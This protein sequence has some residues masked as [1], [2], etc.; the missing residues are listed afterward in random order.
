MLN[1]YEIRSWKIHF[2]S[3][4][5]L[6]DLAHMFN[7]VVQGWVNYY[8]KFYKSQ[9]YSALRNIE[10]DLVLW[11]SR[12][13]K[14]FRYHRKQARNWLGQIRKRDPNLFVHWRLGLGSPVQ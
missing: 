9:L 1:R 3:D 12:K 6:N 7:A 4:K 11:V 8:G 2:R 13:Y 5:S 10:E 14:R